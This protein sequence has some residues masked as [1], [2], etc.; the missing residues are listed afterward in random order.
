MRFLR[1]V[2]YLAKPLICYEN[3]I[4]VTEIWDRAADKYFNAQIP[5]NFNWRQ[6]F[7]PSSYFLIIPPMCQ[8]FHRSIVGAFL[9]SHRTK[10]IL[11]SIF[12]V[13]IWNDLDPH[14]NFPFQ[15]E[16][17]PFK[18]WKN[19]QILD[20]QILVNNTPQLQFWVLFKCFSNVVFSSAQAA[21][22]NKWDIKWRYSTPSLPTA[23]C[24][25][26]QSSWAIAYIPSCYI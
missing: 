1:L 9:M 17:S 12:C 8:F 26:P 4:T 14:R 11:H 3:V 24:T 13:L 2:F 19:H 20:A 15:N 18:C 23:Q 22:A 6:Y 21:A 25:S 7:D 16:L 5:T 10:Q